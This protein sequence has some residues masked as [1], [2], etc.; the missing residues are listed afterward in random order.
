MAYLP[1]NERSE[2]VA[3]M[4]FGGGDVFES[5]RR[6]HDASPAVLNPARRPT[7]GSGLGG[8]IE[9]FPVCAGL[10]VGV[11]VV[12]VEVDVDDAHAASVSNDTTPATERMN[13]DVREGVMA[14]VSRV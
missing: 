1:V 13:S 4:N 14:C 8:D 2:F 5:T 9:R 3:P 12:D 7:R 11:G 6:F 10:A